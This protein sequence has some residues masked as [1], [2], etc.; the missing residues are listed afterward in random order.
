MRL[1]S[2]RSR[3]LIVLR[4]YGS[5]NPL[6]SCW[7]GQFIQPHFSWT[8]FILSDQYVCTFFL[9]KLTNAKI[10]HNQSRRNN[11]SKPGGDLT[12]NLLITSLMLIRLSHRNQLLNVEGQT[13]RVEANTANE[14]AD[15]LES[16]LPEAKVM[17]TSNQ[18]FDTILYHT[19]YNLKQKDFSHSSR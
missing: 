9:Q 2:L 11:V 7:V 3:I 8:G 6:R 17:M 10:F 12:R 19:L 1:E 14:K 13:K 4:F 16:Y 5:V 18:T 15:D